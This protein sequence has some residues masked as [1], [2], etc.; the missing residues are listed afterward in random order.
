MKDL[1]SKLPLDSVED[2]LSNVYS[3]KEKT[4]IPELE[5]VIENLESP[6]DI[7]D[8]LTQSDS[9]TD[10][11]Y[12]K[13]DKGEFIF[14]KVDEKA[15]SWLEKDKNKTVEHVGNI[16][17]LTSAYHKENLKQHT[18]LVVK[19]LSKQNIDSKRKGLSLL[20]ALMHDIGRKY[21]TQNLRQMN[22]LKSE[23]KLLDN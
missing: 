15:K 8:S 4:S 13:D 5:E 18:A 3:E 7:F 19:N 10:K 17:D 11:I 21:T 14:P 6:S 9:L 1:L 20:T 16:G 23:M 22:D 2:I 12:K